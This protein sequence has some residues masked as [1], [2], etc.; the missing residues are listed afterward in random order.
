MESIE[1]MVVCLAT[2]L[3]VVLITASS[4]TYCAVVRHDAF[5]NGYE[6]AVV[7]GR[8]IPVWQKIESE[9]K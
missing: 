5:V 8:Q 4:L 2:I 6:Q 7:P 3:G 9:A 1:S